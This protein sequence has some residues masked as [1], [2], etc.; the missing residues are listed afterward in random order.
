MYP[1]EEEHFGIVPLEGM[2]IGVLCIGHDSGGL[3]ETIGYENGLLIDLFEE[4]KWSE[5]MIEVMNWSPE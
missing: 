3:K 1:V 5:K 2:Q 4:R